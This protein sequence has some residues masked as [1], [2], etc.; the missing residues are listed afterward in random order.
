MSSGQGAALLPLPIYSGLGKAGES[1][2]PATVNLT[3]KSIRKWL[4]RLGMAMLFSNKKWATKWGLSDAPG[5][6]RVAS[7]VRAKLH[8]VVADAWTAPH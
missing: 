3:A 1:D 5:V 8:H 6:G 2:P 7:G 4:R